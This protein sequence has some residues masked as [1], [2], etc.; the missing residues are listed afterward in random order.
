[1]AGRVWAFGPNIVKGYWNRPEATRRAFPGWLAEDR[2][3]GGAGR[4]RL[5]HHPGPRRG[6]ADPRRREH[7][8]HRSGEC[9]DP[10]SGG[11]RCRAG[12]ACPSPAGRGAGRAG[13]AQA[14]RR[15]QR[16]RACRTL[17][18]NGWPPSRCRCM[19]ACRQTPLPR[20]AGRQAGQAAPCA[21]RSAHERCSSPSRIAIPERRTGGT[22]H[23]QLRSRRPECQQGGQRGA[24]ALRCAR[25]AQP[26]RTGA[27]GAAARRPASRAMACW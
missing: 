9:P 15:G 14:R 22:L 11:G 23:P 13:A 16:R 3:S 19:C 24:A 1:M 5:L 8:L 7:L 17:P 2:R 25:L 20:N 27:R 26:A 21:R 4:G 12:R 6:H 18:P 10:A